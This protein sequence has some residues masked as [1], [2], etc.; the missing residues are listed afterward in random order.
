MPGLPHEGVGGPQPGEG[1]SPLL[2]VDLRHLGGALAEKADGAGALGAL[3][4]EFAV[5]AVG[6]PMGPVT[7]EAI[8]GSLKG[9]AEVM[10]P[11]STGLSYL[12]FTEQ[13]SDAS[14]AFSEEDYARLRAVKADLDPGNVIRGGQEIEPG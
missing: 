14:T 5:S 13:P 3:E 4:G 1:R 10:E 7:P 8:Q 6:V 2:Q 9:L 12:N 11:W